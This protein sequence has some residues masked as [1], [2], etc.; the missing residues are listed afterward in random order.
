MNISK[1]YFIDSKGMLIDKYLYNNE[2]HLTSD[3]HIKI[4]SGIYASYT[5]SKQL[6]TLVGGKGNIIIGD[7]SGINYVDYMESDK[8]NIY[9]TPTGI[10]FCVLSKA[11]LPNDF[12]VE[13][14]K[15]YANLMKNPFFMISQPINDKKFTL[16]LTNLVHKY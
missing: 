13:L 9:E 5:I 1:I 14:Y 6:N 10:I 12:F 7:N 8:M 2:N 11:K 16:L 3:Q 15:L 4:A